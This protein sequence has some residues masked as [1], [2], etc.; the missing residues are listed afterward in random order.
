[1]F[2]TP[3]V[4]HTDTSASHF[5]RNSSIRSKCVSADQLFDTHDEEILNILEK[6]QCSTNQSIVEE[7]NEQC[8]VAGNFVSDTVFNVSNKVPSDTEIRIL[9]KGFDFA[10][11][12][13]KV[14]K[15]ELRKDFKELC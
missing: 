15:P 12:Q 11:I 3:P 9:Q 14:N 10:P 4:L 8:S 13:N 5:A 1:M 2:S 7:G 6:L